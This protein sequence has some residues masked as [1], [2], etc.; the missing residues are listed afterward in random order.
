M[1]SSCRGHLEASCGRHANSLPQASLTCSLLQ[2]SATGGLWGGFRLWHPSLLSQHPGR[3]KGTQHHQE[4]RHRHC[5]GCCLLLSLCSLPW[6][7]RISMCAEC[8]SSRC[9]A[10]SHPGCS[11][12]SLRGSLMQPCQLAA[13]SLWHLGLTSW[14][15]VGVYQAGMK[16][17]GEVLKEDSTSQFSHALSSGRSQGVFPATPQCC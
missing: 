15:S 13:R 4:H 14:S 10:V 16:A 11:E 5:K 6:C 7:E 12:C 17:G 9:S 8:Q 1:I 2:W 3:W